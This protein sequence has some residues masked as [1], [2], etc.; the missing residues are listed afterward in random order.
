MKASPEVRQILPPK[1]QIL[2]NQAI[3]LDK[4]FLS[5]NHLIHLVG[6]NAKVIAD[7]H[8]E[9]FEVISL[10]IN[11]THEEQPWKNSLK[12]QDMFDSLYLSD[13]ELFTFRLKF[14]VLF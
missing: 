11:T 8:Q 10:A 4:F 14:K 3:A 13:P 1:L 2:A 5:K 6:K 9:L 12:W 7:A